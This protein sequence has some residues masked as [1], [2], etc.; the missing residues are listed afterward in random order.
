MEEESMQPQP[1]LITKVAQEG[2]IC[3][4]DAQ[5]DEHLQVMD[6]SQTKSQGQQINEEMQNTS[7]MDASHAHIEEVII[8]GNKPKDKE[9]QLDSP[10]VQNEV[11]LNS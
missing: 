1:Y 11:Q 7:F 5:E 6:T 9:D 3:Q 10:C 8:D 2:G 4:I